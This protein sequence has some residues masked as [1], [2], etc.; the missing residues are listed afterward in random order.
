MKNY[1]KDEFDWALEFEFISHILLVE[2]FIL[3]PILGF[4]LLFLVAI[5]VVSSKTFF[6]ITF[7]PFLVSIGIFLINFFLP[8]KNEDVAQEDP[9]KMMM[10][11]LLSEIKMGE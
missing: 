5:E 3:M 7:S 10:G 1:K 9:F 11:E 2:S 8:N 6:I 4:P